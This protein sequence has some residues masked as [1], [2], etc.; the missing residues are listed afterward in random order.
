MLY[1]RDDAVESRALVVQR[2]PVHRSRPSLAGA[3]LPVRTLMAD[4][5]WNMGRRDRGLERHFH[6]QGSMSCTSLYRTGS[7]NDKYCCTQPRDKAKTK[8]L[9][10]A[11]QGRFKT[12]NSCVDLYVASSLVTSRPSDRLHVFGITVFGQQKKPSRGLCSMVS[13]PVQKKSPASTLCSITRLCRTACFTRIQV[14]LVRQ[15]T[16]P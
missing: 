15:D 16:S 13:Q 1:L 12:S 11:I 2:L 4:Y 5:R 3:Q 10:T 6:H 14:L 8:A 7:R 9:S